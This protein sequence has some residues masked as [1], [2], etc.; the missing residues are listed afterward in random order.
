MFF[1]LVAF[2]GEPA[3]VGGWHGGLQ[4]SK[5]VQSAK[6]RAMWMSLL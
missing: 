2:V 1:V 6:C 5:Q 3:D 4:L